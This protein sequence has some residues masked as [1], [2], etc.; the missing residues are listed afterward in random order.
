MLNS[1]HENAAARHVIRGWA[2]CFV[3]PPMMTVDE[4]GDK[5]RQMSKVSNA[6]GGR[7]RSRC[8]Q[9]EPQRECTNREV[10]S[11]TVIG[12][13]Q[14]FG[15][16][17]L[18]LNFIG[19]QA[20]LNPGPILLVNPSTEFTERFSKRRLNPMIQDTRI[21]RDLFGDPK[22]RSS[23][24]TL[25]SKDFPGGALFLGSANVPSDLASDP[26]RD[27]IIDELDRCNAACGN[28]GDIAALAG[29]RQGS[30]GEQA[31]SLYTST[32]SGSKPRPSGEQPQNVSKIMMLFGES[33]QRHWFCPCQKCGASQTLKWA[34]V[35]WDKDK[36]E[37]ARYHCESH[38]CQHP[39]T[40]AERVAMV[41]AGEWRATAPFKG[42]RGYFL[43]GIA[44]LAPP[45]RGSD[46]RLHQMVT[47]FL[48]QK[49]RGKEAL[50]TWVNTF[51]CECFDDEGTE[52][53]DP[54]PLFQ[55][56]ERYGES[57]PEG[58]IKITA[59]VDVHPD[60]IEAH[61]IGWGAGEEG[62]A[63]DYQ[64]FIGDTK[65]AGVWEALDKWLLTGYAHPFGIVLPIEYACVDTGNSTDEAYEFCRKRTMRG[66]MP[67][68][69][70]KGYGVSVMSRPK[71]TGV[72]KVQLWMVSK[73]TALRTLH[74]RLAMTESGPGFI[75]FPRDRGPMFEEEYFKQLTA[76]DVH[77]VKRMG[78]EVHEFDPKGRRDEAA[79]T[80][81]YSLAA[82]RRTDTQF[83]KLAKR[84]RD[85]FEAK[86]RGEEYLKNEEPM[87]VSLGGMQ[88]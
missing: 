56:R 87:V 53:V 32:P 74:A 64:V 59:G 5:Y 4:W 71:R 6:R 83:E 22:S 61:A 13:A 62:W 12:A 70:I 46:S 41:E 40:D 1:A 63:L 49:R 66:V 43:N 34:Q 81:V 19:R 10:R 50:K 24:N 16:T 78:V 72:R 38:A 23:N 80:W 47:D 58:V 76:N 27:V 68:K 82:L 8:Y 39:H 17:E 11:I 86:K 85:E 25:R 51:L 31:F 75:H 26:Q 84:M 60:R 77:V 37:T 52:S 67:V 42:H 15:K 2:K 57:L 88:F 48:R 7:W 79:D 9:R 36:P 29:A 20:H 69:G 30:F 21:L 45:E 33:D 73:N 55:R 44:S 14:T 28:E 65:K 35:K 3:A 18:I 54:H